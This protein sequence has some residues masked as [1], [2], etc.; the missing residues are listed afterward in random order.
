MP[1]TI[2][3]LTRN[4]Y[5]NTTVLDP[6]GEILYWIDTPFSNAYSA[7]Q[8]S[9]TKMGLDDSRVLVARLELHDHSPDF[10]SREGDKRPR[11]LETVMYKKGWPHTLV[12]SCH[13]SKWSG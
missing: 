7:E 1:N 2:F 6:T 9:I 8:T 10:I 3:K 5:K 4:D 12:L 13:I 11:N